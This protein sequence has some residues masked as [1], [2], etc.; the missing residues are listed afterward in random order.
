MKCSG[1]SPMKEA[2]IAQTVLLCDNHSR[3]KYE[4]AKDANHE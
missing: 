2:V 4:I 1:N 3:T